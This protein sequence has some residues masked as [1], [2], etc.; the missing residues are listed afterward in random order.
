MA[1]I[2]YDRVIYQICIIK[3][4]IVYTGSNFIIYG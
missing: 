2:N 1:E 4:Y 3:N